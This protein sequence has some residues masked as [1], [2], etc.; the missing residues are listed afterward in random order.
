MGTECW[1]LDILRSVWEQGRC[2][3]SGRGAED[4]VISMELVEQAVRGST[5][6]PAGLARAGLVPAAWTFME[7]GGAKNQ[8]HR[9]QEK[10][11]GEFGINWWKWPC[12]VR[13]TGYFSDLW[14]WCQGGT[15]Y[16]S[17]VRLPHLFTSLTFTKYLENVVRCQRYRWTRQAQT[18]P[19]ISPPLAASGGGKWTGMLTSLSLVQSLRRVRLFATTWTAACQASLSITNFLSLLKLMSI[20]SVM[21]SNHLILS[22]PLLLMSSIFPSI[23][24]F[25]NESV[26]CVRWP[27][28]WSFSFSITPLMNI[29]DWFP[30]GWTGWISSQSKGFSR[31]FSNTTVQ[32]HQFFGTQLS[33]QSNSLIHTWPLEKP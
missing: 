13:G 10:W 24:V 25:S 15:V 9:S 4:T 6:F 19:T 27:K 3:G 28:Y 8:K 21:L 16:I 11:G 26:L 17:L 2:Y 29:Q 12:R 23:R 1:F 5:L 33:S 31:V 7:T 32:K 18:W 30:L 20:K 14:L 22:H